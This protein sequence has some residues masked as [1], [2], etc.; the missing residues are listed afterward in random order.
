MYVG[1]YKDEKVQ[2]RIAYI[3]AQ[4]YSI[5]CNDFSKTIR[6]TL[7]KSVERALRDIH[8]GIKNVDRNRR[9]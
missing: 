6:T 5:F 8:N 2:E 4:A 1:N 3:V 9:Y 7:L